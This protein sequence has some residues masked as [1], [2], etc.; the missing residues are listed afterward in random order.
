MSSVSFF[1]PI[2][3]GGF[4]RTCGESLLEAVDDYFYL[5]GSKAQYIPGH[6]LGNSEGVAISQNSSSLFKTLLKIVSYCTV[7]IPLIVLLAKM[8]LRCSHQFH[9]VG[10]SAPLP[11]LG[12]NPIG[13]EDEIP[14]ADFLDDLSGPLPFDEP[15]GLTYKETAALEIVPEGNEGTTRF[16]K[17][18][19]YRFGKGISR[20]EEYKD[21]YFEYKVGI[22]EDITLNE[23]TVTKKPF[24]YVITRR[25]RDYPFIPLNT[26]VHLLPQS[27]DELLLQ[28][29][30]FAEDVVFGVSAQ[31][32]YQGSQFIWRESGMGC[33]YIRT[34]K[35]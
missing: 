22:P 31:R 5:G 32:E 12:S 29:V 23:I 33:V 28:P 15:I 7:I 8:I 34:I 30:R 14:P 19:N 2:N 20:L 16:S 9:L 25:E 26:S 18:N 35:A 6:T 11:I 27:H 3:Y 4:A 24:E 1:T 13:G 17:G 21:S 10:T